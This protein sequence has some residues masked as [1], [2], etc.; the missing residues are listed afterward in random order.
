MFYWLNVLPRAVRSFSLEAFMFG[1]AVACPLLT[2]RVG[3]AFSPDV[4]FSP[5]VACRYSPYG[6]QRVLC[7]LPHD[8]ASAAISHRLMSRAGERWSIHY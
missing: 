5:S 3:G 8:A 1:A 2:R 6:L 7:P 4:Y